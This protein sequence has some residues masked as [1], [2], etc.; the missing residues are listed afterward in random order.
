MQLDKEET[1]LV[2]RILIVYLQGVRI[3]S[4]T[5]GRADGMRKHLVCDL[6][7]SGGR[8]GGVRTQRPAVARVARACNW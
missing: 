3:C 8:A 2:R 6:S 4:S 5:G 1:D 7:R